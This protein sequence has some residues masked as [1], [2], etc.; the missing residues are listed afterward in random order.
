MN[1]MYNINELAVSN[2]NDLMLALCA[3]FVLSLILKY[4]FLRFSSSLSGRSELARILP[5]LALIVCVVISI[6][7]SSLALSLGLVGALSIVRFRTPIKEPEELAYI[8]MAI[9]IGIG[10]GAGMVVNTTAASVAIFTLMFL[11]NLRSV[12]TVLSEGSSLSLTI[13]WP[14]SSKLQIQQLSK[15]IENTS[16]GV[17]IKRYDEIEQQKIATFS[18]YCRHIDELTLLIDNVKLLEHTADISIIDQTRVPG[19]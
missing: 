15:I 12:N 11:A 19:V 14:T 6:V 7:K 9:A 4:Y 1:G 18:V 2:V 16:K 8:F 5:F 17:K 3:T 10:N 13:A